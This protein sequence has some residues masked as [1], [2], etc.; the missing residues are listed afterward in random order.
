LAART[1]LYVED[2]PDQPAALTEANDSCI[3]QHYELDL[4]EGQR[5]RVH[6]TVALYSSRDFTISESMAAAEQAVRHAPPFGVLL[7]AHRQAWK[8]LWEECD[9][10]V[11]APQDGDANMKLRLH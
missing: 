10:S 9:I 8:H 4:A 7:D 3:F 2:E 1:E 6:K 5:L 11:T